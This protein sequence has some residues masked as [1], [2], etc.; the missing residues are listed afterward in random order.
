MVKRL[1]DIALLNMSSEHCGMSLAMWDH[2][3]TCH[4]VQVPLLRP[5]A[6]KLL[7]IVPTMARMG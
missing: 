4:L 3:V 7:L 2:S 1:N 5:V 6:C